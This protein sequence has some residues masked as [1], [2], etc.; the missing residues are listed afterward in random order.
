MLHPLIAGLGLATCVALA[1][2]M[3][4]PVRARERVDAALRR[5]GLGLHAQAERLTGWRRRQRLS[6][7]AALEAERA[8]RRAQ[9]SAHDTAQRDTAR[10]DGE[11]VGNVFRP[12]GFEKP[13]KPH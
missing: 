1:V 9:S 12:K 6:R 4:L 5:L 3:A 2:H 11:W 13:K 7:A 10:T 8:I